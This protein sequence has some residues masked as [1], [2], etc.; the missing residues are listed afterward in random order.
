MPKGGM[1]RETKELRTVTKEMWGGRQNNTGE[2]LK[3]AW[4]GR[5]K[6]RG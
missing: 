6:S 3:E 1:G 2:L 5:Q 4:E